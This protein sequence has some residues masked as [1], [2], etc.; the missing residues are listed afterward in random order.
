MKNYSINVAVFEKPEGEKDQAVCSVLIAD[1]DG[2]GNAIPALGMIAFQTAAMILS[3]IAIAAQQD[4]LEFVERV[5]E[6]STGGPRLE[7]P[8]LARCPGCGVR[9]GQAHEMDCPERD[10]VNAEGP[11]PDLLAEVTKAQANAPRRQKSDGAEAAADIERGHAAARERTPAHTYVP[12]P[13]AVD[14]PCA[15]CGRGSSNYLHALTERDGD[16]ARAE[17]RAL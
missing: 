16:S 4:K 2:G 10:R 12:A 14:G 3:S 15:V 8:R 1:N 17:D 11:A 13:G 5:T 7:L 9:E 6:G